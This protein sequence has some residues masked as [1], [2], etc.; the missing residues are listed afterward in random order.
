MNEIYYIS[1]NRTH[2]I[3]IEYWYRLWMLMQ[4]RVGQEYVWGDLLAVES[5]WLR[6]K[7]FL[8]LLDFN[9]KISET[10]NV[11]TCFS[12]ITKSQKKFCSLNFRIQKWVSENR[13]WRRWFIY[14]FRH[15][16]FLRLFG[17]CQSCTW[18]DWRIWSSWC[19]LMT[20][21]YDIHRFEVWRFQ[22][23][24]IASALTSKE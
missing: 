5:D 15:D 10:S 20:F 7:K 14:F 23:E 21:V 11:K 19:N 12:K 9:F 4:R 3:M 6:E 2:D 24:V 18:S 1:E 22:T 13:D 17:L 8:Y 16:Q